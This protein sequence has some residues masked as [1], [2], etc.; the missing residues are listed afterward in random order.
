MLIYDIL[1]KF[2]TVDSNGNIKIKENYSTSIKGV[3]A[4]GDATTW[5]SL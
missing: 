1:K 4:V 5:A 2:A 3:F